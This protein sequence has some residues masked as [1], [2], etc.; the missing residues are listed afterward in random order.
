M[1]EISEN[2]KKILNTLDN[3]SDGED[4]K[5]N[6]SKL[7]SNKKPKDLTFSLLESKSNKI[8]IPKPSQ[9]SSKSLKKPLNY[10]KKQP[11]TDLSEIFLKITS[12]RENKENI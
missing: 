8:H 11:H 12:K 10:L 5:E 7:H 2:Y 4:Q 3:I 1:K 9:K 6:K